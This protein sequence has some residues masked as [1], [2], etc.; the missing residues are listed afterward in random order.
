MNCGTRAIKRGCGLYVVCKSI[1]KCLLGVDT[2]TSLHVVFTTKS[3]KVR[4]F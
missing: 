1:T 2:N 4:I 3:K